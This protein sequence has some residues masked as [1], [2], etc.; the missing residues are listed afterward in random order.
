VVEDSEKAAIQAR[1]TDCQRSPLL[2]EEE[3][4]SLKQALK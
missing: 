1:F 3:E 4:Q 2:A